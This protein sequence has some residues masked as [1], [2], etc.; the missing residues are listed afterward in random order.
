MSEGS[1]DDDDQPDGSVD[2]S[3]SETSDVNP[4]V[5]APPPVST[6]DLGFE[7]DGLSD[8]EHVDALIN[9]AHFGVGGQHV[10]PFSQQLK[11][12]IRGE[13]PV[14]ND[15]HDVADEAIDKVESSFVRMRALTF[16]SFIAMMVFIVSVL[17][18]AI[19][20][21]EHVFV[22]PELAQAVAGLPGLTETPSVAYVYVSVIFLLSL[23]VRVAIRSLY[24]R[25]IEINGEKFAYKVK[26]RYD[27]IMSKMDKC[28]RNALLESDHWAKKAKAWTK[29]ALWC[30]KRSEYLDR[31]ATTAGW[32][33]KQTLNTAEFVFVGL[34][35]VL[36]IY[37]AFQILVSLEFGEAGIDQIETD[38]AR[39]GFVAI[40]LASLVYGWFFL[41][42]F[43]ND[44]WTEKFASLVEE[45]TAPTGNYFDDIAGMVESFVRT[46]GASRFNGGQ[47]GG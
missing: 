3:E 45:E 17:K 9:R 5:D 8:L 29:I 15:I 6:V 27:D 22:L 40:F 16:F 28:T 34:K 41:H 35:A 42:R 39:I 10:A 7:F 24:K 19:P 21:L 32:K 23:V 14:D 33:A 30:S 1:S 26:S 44:I 12:A 47:R 31:Y 13:F 18:F 36:S 11:T 46:I 2:S 43:P 4:G 37:T 20:T 25:E 38:P